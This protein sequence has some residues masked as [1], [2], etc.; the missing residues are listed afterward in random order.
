MGL[1]H[2][3]SG[4]P[5]LGDIEQ[6]YRSRFDEYRRVATA[7]VGDADRARDAVQD[8]FATAV[9][10][11]SAYRG[12]GPLEAWIW[13]AVARS[14]AAFGYSATWPGGGKDSSRYSAIALDSVSQ[15]PS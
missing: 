15:N 9:R 7:I 14:R 10:K 13:R 1:L 3:R 5:S 2:S 12:E 4:T 8:A 6:V 11:R